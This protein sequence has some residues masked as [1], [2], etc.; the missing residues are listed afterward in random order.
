MTITTEELIRNLRERKHATTS[1]SRF[2]L[3]CVAKQ[4]MTIFTCLDAGADPA[5]KFRGEGGDFSNS[6]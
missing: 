3:I 6:W 5:S 4:L 2:R 1:L